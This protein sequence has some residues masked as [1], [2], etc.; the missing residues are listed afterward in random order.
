[1]RTILKRYDAVFDELNK[2]ERGIK[3]K[4]SEEALDD[5]L[6]FLAS[7]YD[8]GFAAVAYALGE[9]ISENSERLAK[10]LNQTYDGESIF[11][12]FVNYFGGGDYESLFRLMESETHRVYN[13]GSFDCAESSGKSLMKRWVTVGDDKVRET[14]R[15]LEGVEIPLEDEF[16]TYDGDSAL[17]P[18]GFTAVQNN[19]NCR[20]I[21]QY[22]E[23]E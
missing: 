6:T 15:Y 23:T 19:V 4:T 14:H 22:F 5:F 3:K 9:D 20:C 17:A 1:M 13:I 10:A 8:E 12:K 18:G 2:L 7:S 21:L 16:Q 11:D